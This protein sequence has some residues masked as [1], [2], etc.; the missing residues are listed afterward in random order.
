MKLYEDA[1]FVDRRISAYPYHNSSSSSSDNN[2]GKHKIYFV[3]IDLDLSTFGES[4]KALDR[5]LANISKRLG[6]FNLITPTV[7]LSGS[8]Y[9]IYIQCEPLD[10]ILEDLHEYARFKE[11]SKEL[12]RFI[13]Y[14]LSGGKCDSVHNSTMSFANCMLR[15]PGSINSG[16]DSQVTI[17]Q[18][19]NGQLFPTKL[20][21]GDF[22]ASL[23]DKEQELVKK[24][25]KTPVNIS[26]KNGNCSSITWIEL[27]LKTPLVDY[28]KYCI[29]RILSPYLMNKRR[30]DYDKSYLIIEDWL[31]K[32]SEL[33]PLDFDYDYKINEGLNG[34]MNKECY[35]SAF[36]DLK[37]ECPELY[38]IIW[39]KII[40]N[41]ITV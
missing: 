38:K 25:E 23:V 32:C 27:L 8:G 10:F 5:E 41:K 35:P 16:T 4:K 37:E 40:W 6:Q 22:L 11:P 31:S 3:L 7:I 24:R 39:N 33:E 17:R 12:L 21:L 13:E 15:V 30:L 26:S 9:H 18:K 36:K 14:Y 2:N 20:I 19:W 29:W 28:R 1:K 34:S